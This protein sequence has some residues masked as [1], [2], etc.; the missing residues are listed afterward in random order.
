MMRVRL[1]FATLAVLV[2]ALST[3]CVSTQQPE[4]DGQPAVETDQVEFSGLSQTL[5]MPGGGTVWLGLDT[6]VNLGPGDVRVDRVAWEELSG[7][8]VLDVR[9]DV[10]RPG[11]L[12][13][14]FGTETGEP[15]T[16]RGKTGRWQRR[17][18]RRAV[19][20]EGAVIPVANKRQHNWT[21]FLVRYRGS[22]GDASPLRVEYTDMRGSSGVAVSDVRLK[23]RPRC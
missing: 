4:A 18:W 16:W 13:A 23:V 19:Q 9:M 17:V 3:A 2:L 12:A 5:C 11:D 1:V 21:T 15:K 22:Q 7:L 20:P 8:E 10:R 14:S 6:F